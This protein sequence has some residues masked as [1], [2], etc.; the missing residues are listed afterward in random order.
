M[1]TIVRSMS[2][3]SDGSTNVELAIDAWPPDV[4]IRWNWVAAI[5]RDSRGSR[6][7]LYLRRGSQKY[8][9]DVDR[10]ANSD[11]TIEIAPRVTAPGDFQV[12]ANFNGTSSGDKIELYAFGEIVEE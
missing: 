3:T 4:T 8:Y 7:D 12:C 11:R 9:F 1:R 2:G 5:C 10:Q 6:T